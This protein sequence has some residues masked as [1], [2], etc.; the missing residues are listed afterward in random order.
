MCARLGFSD[1]GA[2]ARSRSNPEANRRTSVPMIGYSQQGVRLC[3]TPSRMCQQQRMLEI[4][5]VAFY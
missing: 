1:S 2:G 4:L 3:V 5:L